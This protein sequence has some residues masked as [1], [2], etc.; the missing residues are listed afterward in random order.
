VSAPLP[1]L[2][3]APALTFKAIAGTYAPIEDAVRF[4]F[5]AV[6]F[7]DGTAITAAD[8]VSALAVLTRTL[9]AGS[10]ADVWDPNLKTWRAAGMVDLL[11]ATGLPLSPPQTGDAPWEGVLAAAGQTDAAGNPLV[12]TAA[13]GFPQ[14]RL[15]GVFRA[16]R[17]S[18]D[19][20]G[21]GP[22]SA[23]LEF[24]SAIAAARFGAELTPDAAGAT[25]VRIVL[26]NA[27]AQPVGFIE[28]DA[29]GGNTVLTLANMDTG[30]SPLASV[31]L[32]ADGSIR[33]RPATARK[34]IVD[35]DFEADH[36]RYL[37]IGGSVK[38]NLV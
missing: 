25:R 14:Y 21:L 11:G 13:A 15:R 6:R 32:L 24:A 27:G 2:V 23:P 3:P 22:Q 29:S 33:L 31:T 16:R 10:T 37:P 34:V 17:N 28:M 36:I 8:A 5:G 12:Q 20:V 26:R 4:S 7:P 38:Q 35:G 30:G 19:G 9:T 18:T 1:L